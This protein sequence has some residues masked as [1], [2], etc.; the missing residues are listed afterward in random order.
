MNRSLPYSLAAAC[1]VCGVLVA[2]PTWAQSKEAPQV[3]IPDAGV[4]Q[5]LTMEGRYVRAAYNNEAYTILGYR[6]ANLS[7]GED[8]MLLEVGI[9]L[10]EKTKDYTLTRDAVSLSTPDE[11]TIPLPSIEE[12]RGGN[13]QA[14]K[15]RERVQRDSINYFPPNAYQAC[16]IQFFP[17]LDQRAMP[18]NQVELTNHRACLGRFFFK[19]PGGVTYGQHFLNV[20]FADST[21]RVPFRILTKDEEKLLEKHYKSIKK[22]VDEAFRPKKK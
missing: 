5:A 6:L 17:D 16:S 1:M 3:K 22:Q 20:K 14:L 13:T 4:P 11:K 18:W 2:G 9:A 15:A 7:V 19:V 21:L 12:Y 10:R 8:W